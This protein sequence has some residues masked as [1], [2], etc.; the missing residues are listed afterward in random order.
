MIVDHVCLEIIFPNR[1]THRTVRLPCVLWTYTLTDCTVHR[2]GALLSPSLTKIDLPLGPRPVVITGLS[3][4]PAMIAQ[5]KWDGGGSRRM[6]EKSFLSPMERSIIS[7]P[8]V[9]EKKRGREKS[10]FGRFLVQ[11]VLLPRYRLL[12]SFVLVKSRTLWSF[13]CLKGINST[14]THDIIKMIKL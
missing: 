4:R 6:M 5:G 9:R 8:R 11:T 12:A 3:D 10:C 13:W 7:A 14:Y 2:R 1:Q